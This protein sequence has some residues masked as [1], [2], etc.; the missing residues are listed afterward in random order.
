MKIRMMTVIIWATVIA[1]FV[2]SA[3]FYPKMPAVMA[4]HWNEKGQVDGYMNKSIVMFLMPAIMAGE[5]L[6]LYAI[7]LIDPLRKNI[8]KFRIYYEGFILMMTGFLLALHLF[9]IAWN[10]GVRFSMNIFMPLIMGILFFIMGAILP[11]LKPNWFFGI[12]TPWTLSN[13]TVWNK[14][15]QIGGILFKLSA[16]L[17]LFGAMWPQYAIFFVLVPVLSAAVI[18]GL[19]SLVVYLRLK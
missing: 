1:A 6:F 11:H 4:S 14:T 18:T 19:Y 10:L 8:R 3:I 2:I 7:L 12:R 9:M 15:H 16:V 17:V 5:V 13:E